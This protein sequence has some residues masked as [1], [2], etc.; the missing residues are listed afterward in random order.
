MG[1]W[2]LVGKIV[3][4]RQRKL[5]TSA[6][7][8]PPLVDIELNGMGQVQ[9]CSCSRR[10]S[11]AMAECGTPVCCEGPY[12]PCSPSGGR[13]QLRWKYGWL[14]ECFYGESFL[15]GFSTSSFSC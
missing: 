12:F 2:N 5:I 7:K 1:L 14:T 11:T 15:P 3:P 9:G 4:T 8:P 10:P 13:S 6:K